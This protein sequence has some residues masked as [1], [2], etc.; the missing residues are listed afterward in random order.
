MSEFLLRK[1]SLLL[2]ALL[3]VV[4]VLYL[5]WFFNF[6]KSQLENCSESRV[7]T[8]QIQN[9]CLSYVLK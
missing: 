4:Q 7:K 3:F 8:L 1:C 2:N 9:K 6:T 5:Q